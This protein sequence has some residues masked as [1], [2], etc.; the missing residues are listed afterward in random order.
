M[1]MLH[2]LLTEPLLSWRDTVRCRAMTTLPGLLARLGNGELG[3]FPRVR[4]HQFHPWCMFLTQ[5]AAIALYRAGKRGPRASEPQ[6]REMLLALTAGAHEPWCLVVGDLA[7]A[8]FFQPPIPEASGEWNLEDEWKPAGRPDEIDIL[9]TSKA[10]DVKTARLDPAIPELWAYSLV[11]LQ[12]TQGYPGPGYHPVTRMNGGYGNRPRVGLAPDQGPCGRFT[13]EVGVLLD[14]WPEWLHR[15][16]RDAGVGLVWTE[17]W[18]GK[19]SLCLA[20]LS[21]HFIEICERVRCAVVQGGL[22]CFY[23]TTSARRSLTEVANGDV[24]DPWIPVDRDGKALTVGPKGF[25]YEV[26]SR[27]LLGNDFSP[28]VA[29]A[30]R[31][32]DGD[33]VWLVGAAL[34]RGQGKTEGL[35]ECALVLAGEVKRRLGQPDQRSALGRRAQVHVERAKK[36]RSKVLFPCLNALALGDKIVKDTFDDRVNEKFFAE[37]FRTIEDADPVAQLEWEKR[38]TVLARDELRRAID[39]CCLADARRYRAIATAESLFRFCLHKHFPDAVAAEAPE[40]QLV[41]QG[42]QP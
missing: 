13:R 34:A 42:A 14:D 19:S 21:P 6:W 2:D 11:T 41:E 28:A 38:L 39:R 37:L 31:P 27:L 24:G 22:G 35:H 9:V 8:A 15:G 16:F 26:L 25:G 18:D 3:D 4:A 7:R 17:P 32:G 5:L 36:M 33:P 40:T 29:Q 10:H 30:F 12:T 23:T 1:T 20:E